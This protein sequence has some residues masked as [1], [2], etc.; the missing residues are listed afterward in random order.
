MPSFQK[1]NPLLTRAIVPDLLLGHL[2]VHGGAG[3]SPGTDY[4]LLSVDGA[5]VWAC[6]RCA[7]VLRLL[8]EN[9][10]PSKSLSRILS[11]ILS[12]TLRCK[13]VIRETAFR[14]FPNIRERP[15]TLKQPAA[16][17]RCRSSLAVD[18]WQRFELWHTRT[19]AT[20]WVVGGI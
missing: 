7:S 1:Q 11:R 3:G 20:S 8:S 13:R 2:S 15:N 12:R 4:Y 14:V 19:Y 5:A 16:E 17:P 6:G 18:T 9:L 10:P